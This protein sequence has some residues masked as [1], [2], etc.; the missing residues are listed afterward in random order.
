MRLTPVPAEHAGVPGLAPTT[1]KLTRRELEVLQL[2][3][4]GMST[5]EVAAT[6]GIAPR[7]AGTHRASLMGKLGIHKASDLVRFAIREGVITP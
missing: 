7:T 6:L 5:K 2:I 3:A 1:G 4:E